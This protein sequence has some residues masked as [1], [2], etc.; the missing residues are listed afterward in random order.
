MT[1]ALVIIAVYR[2]WSG[3]WVCMGH[4]RGLMLKEPK[5]TAFGAAYTQL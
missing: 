4:N 3:V 2:D 5:A 1:D